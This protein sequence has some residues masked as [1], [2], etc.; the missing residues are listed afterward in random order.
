[1]YAELYAERSDDDLRAYATAAAGLCGLV[2]DDAWWPGVLRNLRTLLTQTD[3]VGR[4]P[5]PDAGPGDG[6]DR[7]AG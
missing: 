1:M 2:I 6:P 7:P 4:G 3:L 5:G